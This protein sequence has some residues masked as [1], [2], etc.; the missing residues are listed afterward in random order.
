MDGLYD[1][2]MRP[3]VS[4]CRLTFCTSTRTGHE[5]TKRGEMELVPGENAEKD[6]KVSLAWKDLWVTVAAG[7]GRTRSILQGSTGYARPGELLAIMGPSG[8][9][10]S[11]LLDALAGAIHFALSIQIFLFTCIENTSWSTAHFSLSVY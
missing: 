4:E 9:G 3:Q 2:S 10:K 8:S 11:T 1:K 5:A 7:K 6:G